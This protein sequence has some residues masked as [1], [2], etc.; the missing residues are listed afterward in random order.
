MF[1][2]RPFFSAVISFHNERAIINITLTFIEI[3]TPTHNERFS[4]ATQEHFGN[5]I[6]VDQLMYR[7]TRLILIGKKL[8]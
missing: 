6:Y 7:K 4:S 8:S 2:A 5:I 1:T 3:Y